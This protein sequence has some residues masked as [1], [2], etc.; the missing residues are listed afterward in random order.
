MIKLTEEMQEFLEEAVPAEELEK[1][2]H[3]EKVAFC[4]DYREAMDMDYKNHFVE[5]MKNSQIEDLREMIG[6]P[7]WQWLGSKEEVEKDL[8][9][10]EEAERL[11]QHN[12]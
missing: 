4:V 5:T 9:L 2:T 10:K 8:E 1:M 12:D 3:E 7:I 6:R 11:T